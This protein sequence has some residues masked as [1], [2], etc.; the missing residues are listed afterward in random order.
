MRGEPKWQDGLLK[1]A[2]EGMLYV[3][4]LK[5]KIGVQYLSCKNAKSVNLKTLRLCS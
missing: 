3:D 2:N 4:E 5:R 1:K